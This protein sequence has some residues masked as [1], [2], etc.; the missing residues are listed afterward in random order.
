MK[1]RWFEKIRDF[2]AGWLR[3]R[4]QT[5][6]MRVGSDGETAAAHYLREQG[7]KIITR[8]WH[9]GRDELDIVARDGVNLVFVEVKS[10]TAPLAR[11]Q[12]QWQGNGYFAVDKRKRHALAR[13]C[14]AYMRALNA[15]PPHFRF[16]IIEV[17]FRPGAAPPE[18]IHHR[19]I[20]LFPP[21]FRK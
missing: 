7:W 20:P 17:A 1:A 15:P 4:R 16:D 19:A 18:I 21:H 11:G 5:A 8:N 9:C 6:R 10:R 13:A 2:L 3:P 12:A 14:R